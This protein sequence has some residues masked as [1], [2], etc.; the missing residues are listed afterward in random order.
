MRT[1][2]SRRAFGASLTA[3]AAAS[4]AHAAPDGLPGWINPL[5]RDLE[6]MADRLTAMLKPWSGPERVFTPE[7]YGHVAGA[8]LSTKAIQAAIDAAAQAGGGVARLAQGDYVSGALDMRSGV[9]LDIAGGARLLGSLNLADWPERIARRRTV[10]D[11]NMGMNQ[12]LIFAEGLR[13]IA[14]GGDGTI[15]GRGGRFHGDETIHGTP[16]RPFLLRVIDCRNVHIS[17]LFMKDSPCWMQNYLNCD[18]LLIE[19]LRVENQCNWNNDGMDIDGCRNVIVRGCHISSGDDGICFKGAAQAPAENIL[20]ENCTVFTSCNALKLG[21]DSQSGFRNVLARNL[22][23]GGV[24]DTM[25]HIKPV[26]AS[27]GISWEMVDGGHAE[28]ILCRNIEIVRAR[29][30]FFLRLDDRGRV[31]PDQPKPPVGSLRRIV[32]E[33]VRGADNGPRGSFFIGAPSQAVEDV[34]LIDVRLSQRPA[35]KAVAEAD[36]PEMHDDY[37]DADM[38]RPHGDLAPAYGLWAR[39]VHGLTLKEYRVTPTGPDPRPEYVMDS[40][41]SGAIDGISH[42]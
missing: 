34:A 8:A 12:S 24:D 26:D 21:T 19:K 31:Q 42:V 10:Q 1:R 33:H 18:N 15:D 20:I 29:S 38:L 36:I 17:G 28:N 6:A 39:H 5:R 14:I 27:T 13:D 37:P 7:A 4:T 40:D 23:L 2:I 9:K 3:L 22:I 16:G 25:R 32:F 30:P 11:T 35:A 41:V